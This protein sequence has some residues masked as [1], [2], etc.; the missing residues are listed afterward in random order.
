M[1]KKNIN[2][3]VAVF[4]AGVTLTVALASCGGGETPTTPTATGAATGAATP[5]ATGAATPDAKPTAA[6]AA[7]NL[8]GNV[9]IDG[10]ST[11]A[12][13]SKAVAEDFAKANPGVK[14]PVG[15]SGTGGG[16][17]KFCAGDTDISNASRPIKKAEAEDCKK[18]GVEFV[19]LPIAIDGLTVVVNKENT[20]AKCLTV[21]ELNTMWSPDSEGKITNWNQIRPDFPSEP[22]AL[23]GAGADS[24]TFD[25]F[26]EAINK[27]SKVSRKDFQP[28]EDD[29]LTIKGVQGN[30]GGLG[31]FG[32]A[33]FEEN[34]KTLTAVEID[35]GKGCV[36]PTAENINNGTYAPLSRPLFIYV[37]KK[38][39]ARPEVKAFVDFYFKDIKVVKEVGY[40]PL[41][42]AALP[43][44][45]ER[46]SAV[47]T[48]STFMD[49]PAGVPIA[50]LL[51][52]DLK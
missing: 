43:K 51:A 21:A 25:Y 48:G 20:W 10:S 11:V 36:A 2:R 15:T 41:P 39:L 40:I 44:I 22:L 29:N 38:S 16:F 47:K 50:E 35:G 17:K 46:V 3:N 14:V 24:G 9:T 31:F 18:N 33:Y 19:E 30:K 6:P 42:E 52:K 1:S 37:S 27:K 5:A 7:S 49:A 45:L 4:V 23:F 26:T 28:S 12:P 32:V 8:T 34:A 13:V